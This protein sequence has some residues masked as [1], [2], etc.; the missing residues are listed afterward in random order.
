MIPE[1]EKEDYQILS[2]NNARM[3]DIAERLGWQSETNEHKQIY[4]KTI[5]SK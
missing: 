2:D 5:P 1:S 3:F 4:L